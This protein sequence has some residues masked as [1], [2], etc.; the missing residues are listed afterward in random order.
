MEKRKCKS[1]QV[2]PVSIC[3][4]TQFFWPQL[5]VAVWL[6]KC[7]GAIE[8]IQAADLE[9]RLPVT[10]SCILTAN[11]IRT[12]LSTNDDLDDTQINNN[13]DGTRKHDEIPGTVR[14][15]TPGLV[16]FFWPHPNYRHMPP[17]HL[18]RS[19]MRRRS[20]KKKTCLLPVSVFFGQP[21]WERRAQISCE[22][23][24]HFNDILCQYIYIYTACSCHPG[25][26]PNNSATICNSLMITILIDYIM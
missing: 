11:Q 22:L 5:L 23:R 8:I 17:G 24:S 16:P 7:H 25:T 15:G 18:N 1:S 19:V 10:R 6:W 13:I 21:P 3:R 2:G 4:V 20:R 14:F 26:S 9:A 12:E